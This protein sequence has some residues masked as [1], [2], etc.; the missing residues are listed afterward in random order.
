M[1][2]TPQSNAPNQPA[3]E[4]EVKAEVDKL[5]EHLAEEKADDSTVLV[6]LVSSPGSTFDTGLKGVPQINPGGVPVPGNQ[7]QAVMDAA[8]ANHVTLRTTEA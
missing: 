1:P 3:D 5:E 2:D 7:F 4:P 8:A 6:H